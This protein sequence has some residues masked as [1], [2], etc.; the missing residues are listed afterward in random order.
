MKRLNINGSENYSNSQKYDRYRDSGNDEHRSPPF[1]SPSSDVLLDYSSEG[2]SAPHI[3]IL[4]SN[5]EEA[6]LYLC[7]CYC[8][9]CCAGRALI[10]ERPSLGGVYNKEA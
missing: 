8:M 3:S 9:F 6:V 10:V 2:A 4:L 7:I 1:P 5:S